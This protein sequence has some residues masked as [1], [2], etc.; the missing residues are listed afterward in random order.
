MY[1]LS[2]SWWHFQM[3]FPEIKAQARVGLFSRKQ[4]YT[5]F[6]TRA[7][8][9]CR[10]LCHILL[11]RD[12][13]ELKKFVGLFCHVTDLYELVPCFTET[14]QKRPT[15][16]RFEF[17]KCLSKVLC[18]AVWSSVLQWVCCMNTACCSVL[19]CC[20]VCCRV[21]RRV[22]ACSSVLQCFAVYSSA[23]QCVAVCCMNKACAVCY[24]V[25][26]YV[27]VVCSVLQCIAVSCSVLH[28]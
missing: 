7:A 26:Q 12:L 2:H 13:Y 9:A 6:K 23:S 19:Q 20:A 15:S 25:L 8:K 14:W 18:V 21:L 22:A 17:W 1:S 5:S 4:T 28:E 3:L 16:F 10:S 24:S 11:K 27:V